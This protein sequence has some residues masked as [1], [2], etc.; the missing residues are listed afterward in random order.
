MKWRDIVGHQANIAA[1][2]RMLESGKLQH[3][4]L[5]TGAAGVGKFTVAGILAAAILC[6]ESRTGEACGSCPSC[7]QLTSGAHPDLITLSPEGQNIKIDQV[8]AMQREMALAPCLSE[9]RV[10]IIDNAE[11]MTEQAANSLLKLLEEPP[12]YL[13]FI[14]TASQRYRLPDTIVSRC[15]LYRFQPVAAPLLEAVLT[16]R[17]VEA[18][19]AAAA[20]RLSGGRVGLALSLAAPDGF[21]SRDEALALLAT[22]PGASLQAILDIAAALNERDDKVVLELLRHLGCLIRDMAVVR[23]GDDTRLVLSVDI[24]AKLRHMAGYWDE[25][26]LSGAYREVRE[27]ERAIA[28][29]A[30][31]RLAIEALCL[32]L[33]DLYKGGKPVAN[34]SWSP[35]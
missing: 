2:R 10:C 9:Y 24:L 27:A 15:R 22:L 29:N 34:S 17:G 3:A 11:T 19:R 28:G 7:R 6:R 21:N 33:I 1:L 32:R 16:G 4:M 25:Q 14:L 35:V 30:N 12:A 20:A 26:T 23:N 5:F 31:T 13:V 8:R 18:R